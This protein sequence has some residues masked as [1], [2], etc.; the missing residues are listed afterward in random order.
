MICNLP[1]EYFMGNQPQPSKPELQ[2]SMLAPSS[3][4]TF[5][6]E[7]LNSKNFKS[8]ELSSEMIQSFRDLFI[9]FTVLKITIEALKDTL[10]LLIDGQIFPNI[11]K[12][13]IMPV[14]R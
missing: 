10:T 1:C 4:E 2:I 7:I 3:A 8:E 9:N 5:R 11:T 6:K 13:E 12:V 14:E